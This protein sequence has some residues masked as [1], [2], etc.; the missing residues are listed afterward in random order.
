MA[1]VCNETKLLLRLAEANTGRVLHRLKEKHPGL[2][3]KGVRR[4]EEALQEY[5]R[6]LRSLVFD[7]ENN[8]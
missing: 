4:L 3:E 7:L 1:E 2:S 6:E 8:G 5:H